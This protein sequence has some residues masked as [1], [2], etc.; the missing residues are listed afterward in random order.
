MEEVT[1]ELLVEWFGTDNDITDDDLLD[2]NRQ[3]WGSRMVTFQEFGF[4]E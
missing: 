3:L 2:L 1:R 4:K